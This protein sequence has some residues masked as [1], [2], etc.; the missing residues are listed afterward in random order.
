[1]PPEM[2]IGLSLSGVLIMLFGKSP[3]SPPP[4]RKKTVVTLVLPD[5]EDVE[6]KGASFENS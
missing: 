2:L 1:M 5:G 3:S 6:F 4:P